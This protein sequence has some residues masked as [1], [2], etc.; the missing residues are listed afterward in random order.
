MVTVGI[1]QELEA[2]ELRQLQPAITHLIIG[3]KRRW[4]NGRFGDQEISR[5]QDLQGVR[6]NSSYLL[7]LV[8]R[9][10]SLNQFQIYESSRLS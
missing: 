6:L 1:T 4:R 3:V 7:F 2:L 8:S 5:Y 10:R 9:H